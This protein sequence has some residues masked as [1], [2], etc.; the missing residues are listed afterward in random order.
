MSYI[1]NP[2]VNG[3][4]R[5]L[6]SIAASFN[7]VTTSFTLAY[8]GS[9]VSPGLA[10]NLIISLG[11]ILQEPNSSFTISSSTITFTEAPRAGTSFW[12]VQLGDVGLVAAYVAITGDTMTGPLTVPNLTVNGPFKQNIVSV[13]ALDIDCSLGNFFTKTI[14]GASAFTFSNAPSSVA[15]SFTLEVNQT[16]GAITWPASV[17]WPSATPPSLTAGKTHLFMFL[18]D[19]GGTKWRGSSLINYTT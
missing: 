6:D 4:F 1:G 16:S 9:P 17:S 14:N 10:T 3:V 12:G 2:P 7:G 19:D 8:S 15:Y 5:K 13:A 11:G 18:T